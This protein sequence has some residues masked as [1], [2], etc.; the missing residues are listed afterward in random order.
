MSTE[1]PDGTVLRDDALRLT[2]TIAG[3]EFIE[4]LA[5]VA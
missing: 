4:G 2:L 1:F 3:R 5:R